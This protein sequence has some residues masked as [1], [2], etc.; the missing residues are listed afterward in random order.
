MTHP[1]FRHTSMPLH[2]QP[3]QQ[4]SWASVERRM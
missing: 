3:T 1:H 2:L 4:S